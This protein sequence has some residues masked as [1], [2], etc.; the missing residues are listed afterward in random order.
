MSYVHKKKKVPLDTFIHNICTSAH[1][2][3]GMR[4]IL[5]TS[6]NYFCPPFLVVGW[7]WEEAFCLGAGLSYRSPMCSGLTRAV[8]TCVY[9]YKCVCVYVIY[10][11]IHISVFIYKFYS[12][13]TSYRGRDTPPFTVCQMK[14]GIFSFGSQIPLH[15]SRRLSFR[16]RADTSSYFASLDSILCSK[17]MIF[18]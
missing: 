13:C 6:R 16:L 2:Q 15:R 11:H 8:R 7:L 18:L 1:T 4:I 5:T 14:R 10:T 9:T 12:R 3:T 17:V